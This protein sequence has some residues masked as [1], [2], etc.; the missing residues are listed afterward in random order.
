MHLW[1]RMKMTNR[2]WLES[3]SDKEFAVK[4]RGEICGMIDYCPHNVDCPVCM[5]QWLNA[6]HNEEE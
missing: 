3:L 2:E 6:E 1:R 4:F 5:V